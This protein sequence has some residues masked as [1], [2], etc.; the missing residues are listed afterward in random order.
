MEK[1]EQSGNV[2]NLES[3]KEKFYRK[4]QEKITQVSSMVKDIEDLDPSKFVVLCERLRTLRRFVHNFEYEMDN[5]LRIH[6]EAVAE[7]KAHKVRD[8]GIDFNYIILDNVRF[9]MNETG[10]IIKG[11]PPADDLPF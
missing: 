6:R 7:D 5:V 9:Y 2:I 3:N 11:Y 8:M 1:P 4:T 10:Q